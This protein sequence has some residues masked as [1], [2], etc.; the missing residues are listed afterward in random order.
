MTGSPYFQDL[1]AAYQA[2][3]DDLRTDSEGTDVLR[4]RLADKRAQFA[5]MLP[6]LDTD[7]LLLAPALHGAFAFPAGRVPA[8]EALMAA[9]PGEGPLWSA[10]A[11]AAQV[12][13]WAAPLVDLALHEPGGEAFLALAAALEYAAA[14][15]RPSADAGLE[16]PPV[17]EPGGD[18]EEAD[19]ETLGEDFLE[20][21][22]FDRRTPQ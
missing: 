20:R 3:L 15:T 11:P 4:R 12:A 21:Q 9:D 19:D 22:G 8:L 2:E 7:P 5:A 18:D 14:R 1:S 16:D 17:R 6:L 13:G 10:I